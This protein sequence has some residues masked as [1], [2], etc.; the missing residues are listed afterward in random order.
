LIQIEAAKLAGR[1]IDPAAGRITV[2]AY[3]A[4]WTARR[5][6]RP[7]SRER[8]EGELRRR[9][10]PAFG[11]WPIA[12][13]RR[14]HIEQ[15]AAG[16]P[17]G[18]S[19]ARGVAATFRTML[20]AAVEDEL[21]ARNPAAGARLPKAEVTPIV[22]LTVEQVLAIVDHAPAHRRGAVV[23]AA[24]TGLRPGEAMGVTVDRI[25]FLRRELRVDRQLYSPP[26]GSPAFAPPKTRRGYRTIALSSIVLDALSAHLATFGRDGLGPDALVFHYA[27]RPIDRQRLPHWFRR[28]AQGAGV[29]ASWHDL[30]HHHASVL[31]S[32]GVSPAIVAERLGH[33]LAELLKTYAHVIRS[34]ED[35]VRAIVDGALGQLRTFEDRGPLNTGPHQR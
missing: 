12:D 32:A 1:Y 34:D 14:A 15:W 29:T 26:T 22:P 23:L 16:L 25:D 11:G 28:G 13:L 21:I 35:R 17:V 30:R 10:L 6:W 31:L 33:D 8:F 4:S 9:I 18:P 20:T 27:G 2:E 5:S 24:G 3:A 7:A 19:S